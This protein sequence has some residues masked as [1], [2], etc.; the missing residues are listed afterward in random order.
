MF[1][2]EVNWGNSFINGQTATDE[3]LKS[4]STCTHFYGDWVGR[5]LEAQTNRRAFDALS[6]LK[7]FWLSL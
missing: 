3:E 2:A 6:F 4:K 1:K 5:W 7:S